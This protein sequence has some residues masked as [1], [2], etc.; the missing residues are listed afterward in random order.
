MRLCESVI[1]CHRESALLEDNEWSTLEDVRQILMTVAHE[2]S[3]QW[4]GNLVTPA[5]WSYTWLSEGFAR[6]LQYFI[7]HQVPSLLSA[8]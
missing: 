3:H 4:F 1:S 2:L 7:M 6:Y 8:T 5:S